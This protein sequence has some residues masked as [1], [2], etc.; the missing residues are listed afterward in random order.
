MATDSKDARA[1]AALRD[2]E[3][4]RG[5]A[6]AA[7]AMLWATD[8]NHQ[9]TFLSREWCDFTGQDEKKGLGAG[10]LEPIHSDDRPSVDA[11]F[12]AATVKRAPF[13]LEYRLRRQDGGYHW[14]M[15]SGRPRFDDDGAFLG[16]VGIVIDIT[17]RKQKELDLRHSRE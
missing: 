10:W 17:E 5:L 9:C 3:R 4:F 11:G 7:P 12:A 14:V 15:D 2:Y 8:A 13:H 1:D 6:D 16:Y